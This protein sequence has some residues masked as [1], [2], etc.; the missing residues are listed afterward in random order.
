MYINLSVTCPTSQTLLP[1]LGTL[2]AIISQEVS[3]EGALFPRDGAGK[4][5]LVVLKLVATMLDYYGLLISSIR[6]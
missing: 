4:Q 5:L 6:C 3:D 2:L 1:I